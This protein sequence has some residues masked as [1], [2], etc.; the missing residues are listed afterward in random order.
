MILLSSALVLG[1]IC[2]RIGL[3]SILGYLVAG[4]VVGPGALGLVRQSESIPAIAEIGV[5]LLLFTIGLEFSWRRLMRLGAVALAGG[6]IM[7]VAL[8]VLGAALSFW[9]GLSLNAAVAIGCV[10]AVSSTAVVLRVLRDRNEMDSLH[11]RSAIGIL[12]LQDLAMVPLVLGVTFLSGGGEGS[13]WTEAGMSLLRLAGLG[14]GLV[15]VATLI[16]PRLLDERVVAKNRELPIILAV[17]AVIA[18]SWAA[19]AAEIS[20]AL[21][22]FIA[23]LLLAEQKFADQMRADILPLRT[24][25]MTVFF[26]SIGMLADLSWTFENILLVLL[27]TVAVLFGKTVVTYFALRP[28]KTPIIDALATAICVSQVGEFSFVLASIANKGGLISP[29]TFQLVIAVTLLTL[30]VTPSLVTYSMPLS[31]MLAKRVFPARKLYESQ[32]EAARQRQLRGHVV[33]IGFG[34]AGQA[35]STTLEE[36]R[37]ES[38]VIDLNPKL[39]QAARERG[40]LGLLGDARQHTILEQAHLET[41]HRVIVAV[42]D[43]NAARI[44][45]SQCKIFAPH[46]PLIAR[47]R[48]HVYAEELD[49]IG[50]DIVVDEENNVGR[51]LGENAIPTEERPADELSVDE[52]H[53]LR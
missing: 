30:L 7:V 13:F 11:G 32:R 40:H 51:L 42:P 20:P 27:V 41:A 2:E 28:F 15:I 19:H 49:M 34:Q 9:G 6:S 45:I 33:I 26:A 52:F 37:V 50:A 44:I 10:V 47:S 22:A 5:A 21:G 1:L 31:R 4:T 23:G 38:V 16:I 12:L 17:T 36:N 14:V 48:Y 39:V 3:S 8:V 29:D 46:V 35:A 53:S 25:F 18:A 43:H 24:L